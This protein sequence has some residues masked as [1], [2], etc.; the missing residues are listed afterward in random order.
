MKL[1]WKESKLKWNTNGVLSNSYCGGG[2]FG[3]SILVHATWCSEYRFISKV[4][5]CVSDSVY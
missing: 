5:I 3:G 4:L 2:Y 1:E